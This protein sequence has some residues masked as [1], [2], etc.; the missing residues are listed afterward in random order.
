MNKNSRQKILKVS[1][2][3]VE[4]HHWYSAL[5]TYNWNIFDSFNKYKLRVYHYK[6]WNC[7][8]G[9]FLFLYHFTST[10]LNLTRCLISTERSRSEM[11]ASFS[12]RI[13]LHQAVVKLICVGFQ[14]R[15]FVQKA[16]NIN[17]IS[18]YLQKMRNVKRKSF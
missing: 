6:I 1:I 12:F 3:T 2:A 16:H 9:I 5:I 10:R 14:R 8:N 13:V 18:P 4:Y 17:T 11:I 7:Y 15:D